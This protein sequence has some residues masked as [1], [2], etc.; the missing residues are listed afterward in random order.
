MEKCYNRTA[1]RKPG[2]IISL[3]KFRAEHREA[4]QYDLLCR[5]GYE[6]NDIGGALSWG[7][8]GSFVKNLDTTSAVAR[9]VSP[10]AAEW[11]TVLKT[12]VILADIY[13]NLSQ[14]NANL[15]AF[16]EHKKAKKIKHYPR[17]W[18]KSKTARKIGKGALPKAELREWIKNYKPKNKRG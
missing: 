10:Y 11:S 8:F 12:N 16:V 17:P 13:D 1:G 7:A 4:V 9:E 15:C 5:T 14:I 2:G 18:Q 3:S 6:L